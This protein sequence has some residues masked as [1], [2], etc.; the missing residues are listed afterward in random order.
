MWN[1][2]AVSSCSL[3]LLIC[4]STFPWVKQPKF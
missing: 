3:F 4:K 2:V 1:S